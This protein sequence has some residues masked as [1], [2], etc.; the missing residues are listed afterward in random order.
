MS[1][2]PGEAHAH[3]DD[4]HAHGETHGDA[5]GEGQAHG[6]HGHEGCGCAHGETQDGVMV[7]GCGDACGCASPSG[8]L[9]PLEGAALRGFL[10]GVYASQLDR[11][12]LAKYL[13][14]LGGDPDSE[15]GR[16]AQFLAL[17]LQSLQEAG[18]LKVDEPPAW[19]LLEAV[20]GDEE[21]D[22]SAE[23]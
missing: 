7:D 16:P 3:A 17:Q 12:E 9:H 11:E 22:E 14:S 2:S 8:S 4:E 15:F 5:Q 19:K 21:D 1:H 6:E 10:S 23:E 13:E 20:A 18:D